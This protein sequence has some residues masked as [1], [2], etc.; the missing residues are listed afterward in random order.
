MARRRHAAIFVL[1]CC[2][3]TAAWT[4]QAQERPWSVLIKG[5][6][7][8]SSQLYPDPGSLDPV[9]RGQSYEL[10]SSLGYAAEVRYALPELRLALGVSVEYI[11]AKF[12]RSIQTV[13]G[14]VIPMT[15]G[16]K[17]IPVELT[18]YFI[19]PFSGSTIGMYIGA[20]GGLYF[21]RRMLDEAGAESTS[22]S[23]SPGAGIHVL[24]GTSYEPFAG[25]QVLGEMKFRDLQ[26]HGVNS[27]S[28]SQT[29]YQGITVPLEQHQESQIHTDGVMFQIGLAVIL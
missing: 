15:D 22:E 20:G 19:I 13:S 12:D 23:V 9:V 29:V 26:F 28:A 10:N 24:V 21:G 4:V 27:Y 18:G 16:Y 17:V 7:T 6:V 8:T 14:E 3:I 2:C 1:S 5:T 25:V 11:H